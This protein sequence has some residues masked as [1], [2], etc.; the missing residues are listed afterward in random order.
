MGDKTKVERLIPRR[1]AAF[2][3]C[4]IRALDGASKLSMKKN[5][6]FG[7][8]GISLRSFP[9]DSFSKGSFVDNLVIVSYMKRGKHICQ[10]SVHAPARNYLMFHEPLLR[11]IVDQIN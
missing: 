6:G 1:V 11:W 10:Y 9:I 4:S 7:S 2:N 8:K 5:W 3:D